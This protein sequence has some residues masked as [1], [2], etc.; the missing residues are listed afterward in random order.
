M[1]TRTSVPGSNFRFTI[2]KALPP[3]KDCGAAKHHVNAVMLLS[4][5]VSRLVF[6]YAETAKLKAYKMPKKIG[7]IFDQ[8]C[9]LD[10][11]IQADLEARK[12]KKHFGVYPYGIRVFDKNNVDNCLLKQL[13]WQ[14][15]TETYENQPYTIERRKTDRKWRDLYKVNYYPTHI[16]HHAVMRVI[17]PYLTARM[18]RHSFA[19]TEGKG[20]TQAADLLKSYLK[21]KEGTK[22]FLQEDVCKFYP[23]IDQDVALS[24]FSRVFKDRKFLRLMDKLLH[25]TPSG[26]QI[27][28]YISQ[29]TANYMYTLVDRLIT[30]KLGAKYYVRFCDDM[31]ILSNDRY[32]LLK[33]HKEIKDLVEKVFHQKIHDDYILSRIGYELRNDTHRK[34]QRGSKGKKYRLSRLSV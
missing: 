10:N 12:N 25:H 5:C 4:V 30:E 24:I 33:V 21:D 26:L 8:I 28:F 20:T 18:T 34:R 29:L 31:V 15:E 2:P 3:L 13:L 32:F 16:L 27:G 6:E 7:Y 23:T 11:L 9:T 17:Y 22:Y 14:L 19:G 1:R